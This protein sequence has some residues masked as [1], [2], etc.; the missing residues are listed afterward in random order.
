MADSE[1]SVRSSA[2]LAAGSQDPDKVVDPLIKL[3]DDAEPS[4]AIAACGSLGTLKSEE[5]VA[6]LKQLQAGDSHPL[7]AAA[8]DALKATGTLSELEAARA[9][10][11]VSR[12]SSSEFNVLAQAKDKLAVPELITTMQSVDD[13]NY[14]RQIATVLGEIGDPAAVE[15]LVNMLPNS[16]YTAAE[17]ITAALGKL[18]DKRA[19]E[20]LQQALQRASGS[21]RR[22]VY[23]VLLMLGAPG[24][25]EQLS[26]DL[27][28]TQDSSEVDR[29]LHL[30][31]RAG[32]D[33]AIPVIEPFLEAGVNCM[34]PMEPAAN[35][36]IV[37]IREKYGKRLAFYGGLDKHVIRRTKAEIRAELEYKI[38]PMVATGGCVL[39][40]DHRIP[41]GTP[42]EN[43]RY[44]MATAWEIL[45]REASGQG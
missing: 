34:H 2:A 3:L 17:I 24:I 36:D 32:G 15:P 9:K 33:R 29:L 20:P 18:G 37:A 44:Y 40:L 6:R 21:Q 45:N 10:L 30:L 27:N 5:A 4:V 23:E 42:L 19:I 1:A 12:L 11:G 39:G 14:A 35:M 16:S 28:T 13:S 7:A 43:Y 22:P 8:I 41:N 38:P 25:F 31:G 26:S